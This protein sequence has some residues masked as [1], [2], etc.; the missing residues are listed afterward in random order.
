L[1]HN[2]CKVIFGFK[3]IIDFYLICTSAQ[4]DRSNYSTSDQ[5]LG[6]SEDSDIW[7]DYVQEAELQDSEKIANWN[8]T[9]DVLLVFV[10]FMFVDLDF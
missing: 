5:P 7:E 1:V 3:F 6:L 9:M 8:Q 2:L 4:H 10:S